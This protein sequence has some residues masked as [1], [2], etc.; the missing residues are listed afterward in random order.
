MVQIKY[1]GKQFLAFIIIKK[2]SGFLINLRVNLLL[3]INRSKDIN[4][5][6]RHKAFK[7]NNTFTSEDFTNACENHNILSI[8]S[9]QILLNV[10]STYYKNEQQ[11]V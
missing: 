5:N 2:Y 3:K 4:K 6:Q 1:I 11:L 8:K 9:K 10:V 7:I